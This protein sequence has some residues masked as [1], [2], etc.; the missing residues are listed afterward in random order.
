[1]PTLRDSRRRRD[2]PVGIEDSRLRARERNLSVRH[3]HR[4][5]IA[6]YDSVTLDSP[7]QIFEPLCTCSPR[8]RWTTL[9]R[10]SEN[11]RR[12]SND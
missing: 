1:M 12:S 3:Q 6:R 11:S 8:D 9:H 5:D 2:S 4:H 7:P 10:S